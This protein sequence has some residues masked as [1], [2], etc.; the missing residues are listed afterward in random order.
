[1]RGRL[2]AVDPDGGAWLRTEAGERRIV[3][4]PGA[5]PGDLIEG[6]GAGGRIV[7]HAPIGWPGRDSEVARLPRRRLDAIRARGRALAAARAVLD[8]GGFVEIEAPVRVRAPALELHIDAVASDDGWLATSPEYQ[9][10][11]LLAGGLERIYTLGRVLRGGE[12]G[13]HHEPEF[14]MLE[15]YRAWGGWTDVLADTEAIVAAVARAVAGGTRVERGGRALELAGPVDVAG[16]E[17]AEVLAERCRA[18]GIEL[19]A[20]TAWDDVFFTAFLERVEPRLA[21]AATPIVVHDWPAPLAAL[22]RRRAEDPRVAER[23][24]VYAGGLELCNGYGELVDPTEQRA[25]FEADR[26]ARAAAGKPVHPLDERLLA[27][28]AEGLPPAGGNAL[29]FDRVLMLASGAATIRE[30]TAFADDE[31]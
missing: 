24:E 14:T 12:R 5:R 28:L 22:A 31:L 3:A 25:R 1:V 11:R 20:A 4:P 27:A 26:A 18:A 10:K 13:P 16:D 6:E 19:G 7:H 21:E 29:G 9:H 23:F 15:W 17:P 2:I 8:E 30:V